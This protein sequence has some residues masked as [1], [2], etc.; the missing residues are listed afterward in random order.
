MKIKETH[1][2]R[3]AALLAI[4]AVT[5]SAGPSARVVA[6]GDVHGA[7]PEF[8]SI[9]QKTQLINKDL[10]WSGGNATFVQVGDVLDRGA[11]S[12]KALDLLM[13][14]EAQ[15]GKQQGKVIPLMGNHEVMDMLGDL[16]YVS[17][18]EYRAF[19]TDQSEK[20]REQAFLDYQT[21]MSR[22]A[23]DPE[24]SKQVNDREKWMAQHPAGFF[25]L[26]DAY[27]P[28][29]EYGRWFRTHDAVTQIGDTIFLHGG[30]NPDLHFRKIDELN[31]HVHDELSTFDSLWKSLSD[32][33][34]VWP[35]MT[36]DE[37]FRYLQAELSADQSGKA[38]LS[39]GARADIIKLLTG[40]SHY[41]SMSP[42][43]P[44]WYRGLAQL[45]ESQ[46]DKKLDE[47]LARLNAKHIVM[48]HTV[49]S[50]EGIT[51][52]F[53]GKVFLIDTGMLTSYFQGR[54]S[55]LE[56]QDGRF[57]AVY[58]DNGEKVLLIPQEGGTRSGAVP[59]ATDGKN[60]P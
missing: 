33:K 12:R 6:I 57:S 53:N 48:G 51:P 13:K 15:A 8:V 24:A 46:L 18:G 20:V 28:K 38:P 7:Y 9:L 5:A 29:G 11:E 27:G 52:R 55:A 40:L 35:Y 41:V 45:P 21:F 54:P 19:A 42:E 50:R 58:A 16:R 47:M 23:M 10:N 59:S 14:L 30:L 44:L 1:L 43:G 49:I 39:P 25:E 26:R 2:R 37:A 22:R 60:R 3:A 36:L 17:A 56:I 4:I 31:K 34:A 32:Q